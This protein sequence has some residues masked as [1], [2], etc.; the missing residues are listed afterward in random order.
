MD[1]FVPDHQ[2]IKMINLLD[3]CKCDL[4]QKEKQKREAMLSSNQNIDKPPVKEDSM[5]GVN[6]VE[7]WRTKAHDYEWLYKSQ[8]EIAIG[9][10]EIIEEM[11][12][13]LKKFNIEK[14]MRKQQDAIS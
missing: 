9:Y 11:Q 3:R 7:F 6:E 1:N 2:L 14:A 12:Q 4:C 13:Q 8:K 5:Q 10:K